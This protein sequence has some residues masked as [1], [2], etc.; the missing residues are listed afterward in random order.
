MEPTRF[1][2]NCLGEL[3]VLAKAEDLGGGD[4]TSAMLPGGARAAGR[5]VARQELVVCGGAFLAAI[6]AAYDGAIQTNV[7]VADGQGVEAGA[8]LA[9]W[10]GPAGAVLSAERVA[11]N[12]LQRLCGIATLTREYVE[13]VAATS[14]DIYDT[15]KTTPGWRH[16]EKY[17]VRAGGGHNHRMGLYDAVLVKDNHLALLQPLAALADKLAEARDALGGRGFVEVEVDTLEQFDV[18]LKL[19]VDVILLD[20]F[21]LDDLA[22]AV[23]RR[24]AAGLAGELALEASGGVDLASVGRIAAT[25]VDRIAIGALTHSA[26]AADVAFDID[27]P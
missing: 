8:T 17:A 10:S 11:L 1:E 26:P 18:A 2:F 27:Q 19:P 24:D 5:F 16:L 6:G 13:A 7:L 15:R 14:A 9:Q 3:L 23:R 21:T 4:V 12:F 25:G 22:E 20:N